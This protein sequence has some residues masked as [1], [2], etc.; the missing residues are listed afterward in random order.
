MAGAQTMRGGT[1]QVAVLPPVDTSSWVPEDVGKYADQVRDQF[2]DT[3]A[4][5]P[6]RRIAQDERSQ[7]D[8]A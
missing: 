1:V 3:L 7:E 8:P 2:L 5:W 4:A 6:E